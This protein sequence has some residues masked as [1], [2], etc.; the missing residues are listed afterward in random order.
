MFSKKFYLL[1]GIPGSRNRGLRQYRGWSLDTINRL[2]KCSNPS[3]IILGPTVGLW[4]LPPLHWRQISE[5]LFARQHRRC[6][7]LRVVGIFISSSPFMVMDKR[8]PYHLCKRNRAGAQ[9][10]ARHSCRAM[11]LG[12]CIIIAAAITSPWASWCSFRATVAAC[13]SLRASRGYAS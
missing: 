11:S 8:T 10:G 13:A 1:Y 6:A 7:G 4:F 5:P 2:K 12:I 3:A 9:H